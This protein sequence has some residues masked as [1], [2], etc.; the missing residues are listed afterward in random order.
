MK[1][2]KIIAFI[3]MLGLS[4]KNIFCSQAPAPTPP[5]TPRSQAA[6]SMR[7]ALF[8]DQADEVT[9]PVFNENLA[10]LVSLDPQRASHELTVIKEVDPNHEFFLRSDKDLMLIRALDLKV[11]ILGI[12]V[13]AKSTSFLAVILPHIPVKEDQIVVTYQTK[14]SSP[15]VSL[16]DLIQKPH[17]IEKDSAEKITLLK[18]AFTNQAKK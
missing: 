12:A 10:T 8:R 1:N 17:L 3:M 2:T 15:G 9:L 18:S 4:N 14:S 6:Q 13:L 11:S 7:Q 16:S 5:L